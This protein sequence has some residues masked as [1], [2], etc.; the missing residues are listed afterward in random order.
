MKKLILSI[1]LLIFIAC[2]KKENSNTPLSFSPQVDPALSP[3][4]QNFMDET[5]KNKIGNGDPNLTTVHMMPS[6]FV[7]ISPLEVL[8]VGRC[9]IHPFVKD[10]ISTYSMELTIDPSFL[11]IPSEEFKTK[12]FFHE[13][14][15]CAYHLHDASTEDINAIMHSPVHISNSEDFEDLKQQFFDDARANETNWDIH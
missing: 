10:G 9:Y 15:H 4:F 3:Y 5:I 8:N 13:M 7:K 11:E 14:G 2:G 12:I 6:S 1:S